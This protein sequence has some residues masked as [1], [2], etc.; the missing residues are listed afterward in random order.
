MSTEVKCN[1]DSCPV[2]RQTMKIVSNC[3]TS[4]S[5]WNEASQRKNCSAFASQCSKP[6]KFVYHCVIN[7]FVDQLLEVCAYEKVI[8]FGYCTEYSKSGNIIQENY[9]TNCSNFT[10]N[11][12]PTRYHSKEAY[13]YP[14]C[15]NLTKIPM[16]QNSF[17][18]SYEQSS[19][20]M[21]TEHVTK[22]LEPYTEQSDEHM[23]DN[24]RG[25]KS[26]IGVIAVI[27]V[28]AIGKREFYV[29]RGEKYPKYDE[30]YIRIE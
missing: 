8:V 24:N 7:P 9:R 17:P 25:G 5:E 22:V 23:E 18:I 1:R 26:V 19:V 11:P 20:Y 10:Q 30:I 14:G 2:S 12:C 27:A 4:E 28:I 16:V 3:P 15:Y 6:D 13:K 21:R 29:F